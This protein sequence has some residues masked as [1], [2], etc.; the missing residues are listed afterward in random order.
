MG[1]TLARVTSGRFPVLCLRGPA[2]VGKS[3]V[4]WQIFTEVS[5]AGVPC[6]Y[7]DTDQLGLCYPAPADDPG[8]HGV[9]ARNLGAVLPSYRTAG[10]DCLVVSGG[11][12]TP[13]EERAYAAALGEAELTLCR[14]RVAPGVLRSRLVGRGWPAQLIDDVVRAAGELDAG[15][16]ADFCVDTDGLSVAAVARQVRVRVGHWPRGRE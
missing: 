10:A 9:K 16:G 1:T 14:L 12:D 8:N 6:G 11:P 5:G 15:D 3:T 7:V 4:A 2:G 13:Q